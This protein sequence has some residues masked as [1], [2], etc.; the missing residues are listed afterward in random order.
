[1]FEHNSKLWYPID[2]KKRDLKLAKV[3]VTLY[4]GAN[5][6]LQ[7]AVRYLNQSYQMPDERG[8]KL[9]TDIGTEELGHV[10]MICILFDQ[11]TKNATAE[12]MKANGLMDY[13]AE[14]G[15][16]IFMQNAS[17]IPYNT[18]NVGALGDV[19][20]DLSEDMAAEEKAR[21]SY[22]N[23]MDLTDDTEVLKVLAFLRERELVHFACFKELYDYYKNTL[24]D[25]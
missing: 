14:H 22:E 10:E 12:E 2:I 17:G 7:A 13:Y 18:F 15:T 25:E 9:L 20:A 21:A 1:M 8:K 11:L 5:G 16:E 6:E 19:F 3:L 24:T 4:G 23:I